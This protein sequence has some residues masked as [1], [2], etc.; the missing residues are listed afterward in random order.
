LKRKRYRLPKD[1]VP[2]IGVEVNKK[3]LPET[4]RPDEKRGKDLKWFNLVG[5]RA[6][7]QRP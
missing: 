6:S 4:T 5:D 3:L 7:K 2:Q 1:I